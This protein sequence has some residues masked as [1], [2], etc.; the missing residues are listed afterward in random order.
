MCALRPRRTDVCCYD[1]SQRILPAGF[2]YPLFFMGQ[3][4][5]FPLLL[6]STYPIASA[7]PTTL[8]RSAAEARAF[9][10]EE[11]LC[12]LLFVV[13]PTCVCFSKKEERASTYSGPFFNTA[14]VALY[15]LVLLRSSSVRLILS[16]NSDRIRPARKHAGPKAHNKSTGNCHYGFLLAAARPP[17]P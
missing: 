1:K 3:S 10:E 13:Q 16:N 9:L 2:C 15:A 6:V 11:V 17:Y 8:H 7:R 12:K 4:M 5:T 14:Y